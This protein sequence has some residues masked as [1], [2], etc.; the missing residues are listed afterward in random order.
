MEAAGQTGLQALVDTLPMGFQTLLPPGGR[1]LSGGQRQLIA[2]TGALASGRQLL[3]LDEALANLDA[4]HAAP[5][6]ERLAAGAW[7]M[8]A[9][10]HSPAAGV[11]P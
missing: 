6:R 3:L 5:L 1:T 4:I 8:V 9:A 10:S 2:L 7:T 11:P